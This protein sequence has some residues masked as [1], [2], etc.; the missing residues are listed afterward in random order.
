[1]LGTKEVRR[2]EDTKGESDATKTVVYFAEISGFNG[3][4]KSI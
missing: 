4:T 3:N 2:G 1:M